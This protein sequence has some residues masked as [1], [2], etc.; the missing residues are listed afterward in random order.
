MSCPL[1]LTELLRL[2]IVH[3]LLPICL[4]EYLSR[5]PA[6]PLYHCVDAPCLSRSR[7]HATEVLTNRR[8]NQPTST[9]DRNTLWASWQQ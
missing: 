6:I 2:C 4:C 7:S 1:K 3:N 8:T 9:T 5:V